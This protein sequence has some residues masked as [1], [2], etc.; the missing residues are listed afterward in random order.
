MRRL[1]LSL[2]ILA[3]LLFPL[4]SMAGAPT[5]EPREAIQKFQYKEAIKASQ[6][7]IGKT[8]AD[9]PFTDETGKAI[10]LSDLRGKPLVLSM[11]YTSCFH[12]CPMTIKH[13]AKVVAKAKEAVDGDSFQVAIL[14]FDSQ[15]DSPMAM[16]HFAKQQ[17]VDKLGWKLLSADQDT[18]NAISKELGFLFFTSP[19]GYDHVVQASVIDARGAVYRQVYGEVFETPLLVEPLMELVFDQPKPNQ[20]FVSSLVDKVRFFCTTYDPATDSYIFDYSLYLGLLIGASI[21]LITLWL[22]MRESRQRKSLQRG[23]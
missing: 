5:L 6:D 1:S 14:G 7:A 13:L 4:I 15:N 12:I 18:I 17:G 16:K 3:S 9:Y 23:N 22:T 19:N 2:F 21:L 10:N 11:V 20:D 8:L